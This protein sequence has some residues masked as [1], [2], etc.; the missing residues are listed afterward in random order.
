MDMNHVAKIL[1]C[2]FVVSL[3]VKKKHPLNA[4]FK[5]D[6]RIEI[7]TRYWWNTKLFTPER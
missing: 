2:V 4:R 3:N 5:E 7:K 6:V 1:R